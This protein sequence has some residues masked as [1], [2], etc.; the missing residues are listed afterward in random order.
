MVKSFAYDGNIGMYSAVSGLG[1]PSEECKKNPPEDSFKKPIRRI[2]LERQIPSIFDNPDKLIIKSSSQSSKY[3]GNIDNIPIEIQYIR[4]KPC[5]MV[6]KSEE[7]LDRA[8]KKA[9]D[10]LIHRG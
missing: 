1:D 9:L 5:Y 4:S 2:G 3:S 7:D 8:H 6:A 10:R